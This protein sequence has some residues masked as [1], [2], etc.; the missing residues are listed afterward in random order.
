[1][2]Y[3]R[4]I[5][6]NFILK[7]NTVMKKIIMFFVII[8]FFGA[9]SVTAQKVVKDTTN[10]KVL[11]QTLDSLA[12]ILRPKEVFSDKKLDDLIFYKKNDIGFLCRECEGFLVVYT[13]YSIYIN[14]DPR[15][16]NMRF[17]FKPEKIPFVKLE[18]IKKEILSELRKK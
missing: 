6:N 3:F 2:L 4:K 16:D 7:E 13:V 1:M 18:R 9:N 10:E 15:D 17:I 14:K 8:L 11:Y 5:V 12:R